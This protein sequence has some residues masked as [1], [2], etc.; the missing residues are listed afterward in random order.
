M[1]RTRIQVTLKEPT[2]VYK[3]NKCEDIIDH[4]HGTFMSEYHFDRGMYIG[5]I[6][7][8]VSMDDISDPVIF[9]DLTYKKDHESIQTN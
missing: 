9:S 4:A 6:D 2:A 5:S 1:I 8:W 3:C 7:G